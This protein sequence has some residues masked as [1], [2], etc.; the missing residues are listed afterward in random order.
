MPVMPGKLFFKNQ[1]KKDPGE[2][3]S[4][5]VRQKAKKLLPV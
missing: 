2:K 3:M 4:L 1:N 5:R